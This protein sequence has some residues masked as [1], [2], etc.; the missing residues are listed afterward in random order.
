MD[1]I[2][3]N[4]K[5]WLVGGGIGSLA[6]AAFNSNIAWS[7]WESFTVTLKDPAFFEKMAQFSGNEAGTGGLVTFKDS[8]WLMS[9]VLAHQ[10]HFPHQ[11][12]LSRQPPM[13]E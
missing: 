1:K 13:R 7:F 5:A 8:N 9:V 2:A 12:T 3:K 6:A 10:P 4:C 11:P